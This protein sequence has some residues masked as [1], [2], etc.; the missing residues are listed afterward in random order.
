MGCKQ[1]QIQKDRKQIWP[2]LI[3]AGILF[4]SALAVVKTLII[5]LEVD[6]E[7]AVTLGYRI[8]MGD[9][10]FLEMWEPHQTSAFLDAFF[11]KLYMLITGGTEYLVLYLRV[12]GT[13]LQLGIS[14]FLYRTVKKMTDKNL[15]F[16][17]AV[18]FFHTLPKWIQTPEFAN[19]QIWFCM[20][21]LL[22]LLQ[23]YCINNRRHPMWL[24]CAAVCHA[25]M[26][27]AYPSCVA[28]FPLY[29]LAIFMA[30]GRRRET[31]KEMG[32]FGITCVI[33]GVL[34][35]GYFL[36]SMPITDF[37]GGLKQMLND[38]AHNGS[39]VQK[40]AAYGREMG[41][42]LIHLLAAAAAG[43]L[44][45]LLCGK[46]VSGGLAPKGSMQMT[47]M[48]TFS[49]VG[50]MFIWLF[51]SREVTYPLAYYYGAVLIGILIYQKS[52][53]DRGTDG[54]RCCSNTDTAA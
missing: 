34:Y 11:I 22:C 52:S 9:R 33:L 12:I 21:T 45:S 8:A 25:A 31:G 14:V 42:I 5:G 7:Y 26:I 20:L 46:K 41:M 16:F 13:M 37:I 39:V 23:Y 35:I 17:L 24:V 44:V 47:L 40:F 19:M 54:G 49:Y 15:A 32:Y 48:L 2:E 27:L 4:L 28:V 53:S 1:G 36:I 50:Q 10:M 51:H 38:G 18:L 30:G 43:G 6:E 29:L 3:K